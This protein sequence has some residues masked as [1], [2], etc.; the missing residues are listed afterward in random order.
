MNKCDIEKEGMQ[1]PM[2]MKM[3]RETWG[4][5]CHAWDTLI[6]HKDVQTLQTI[7]NSTFWQWL[8]N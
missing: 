1:Y 5:L 4:T 7:G 8:D 6:L 3:N 2:T